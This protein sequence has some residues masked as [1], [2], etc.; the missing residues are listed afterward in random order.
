M[1]ACDFLQLYDCWFRPIFAFFVVDV[2]SKEV[3]HVAVTRSPSEIWTTQQLREITPFGEC[4]DV[5]IRDRDGKFGGE[6]DRVA[7]CVGMRVVKTPV[8]TPNMNA[9]CERFLGSVRREC[10]DHVLILNERPLE[11]V[12]KEYPNSYFNEARPHQHRATCSRTRSARII[13]SG[14][15][16]RCAT[17]ARWAPSR[18]SRGGMT[19]LIRGNVPADGRGS[20]DGKTRRRVSA[21]SMAT[22]EYR[23]CPPRRPS[24]AGSHFPIA[25]SLS[26]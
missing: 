10:L 23:N 12:L 18:L 9:V 11:S 5:I 20:Q 15:T 19:R 14:S 2:N 17:H 16:S 1:W 26:Q 8:R 21:V 25:S 4:A 13:H 6:F 3:I 22:S 7:K 24:C